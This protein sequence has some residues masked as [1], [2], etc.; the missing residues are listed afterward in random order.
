MFVRR[1]PLAVTEDTV[2]TPMLLKIQKGNIFS[3]FEAYNIWNVILR[4]Q[5]AGTFE[6]IFKLLFVVLKCIWLF[7]NVFGCFPNEV[8]GPVCSL[9]K[10]GQIDGRC[11]ASNFPIWMLLF[12][13]HFSSPNNICCIHTICEVRCFCFST[14]FLLQILFG[15]AYCTKPALCTKPFLF[16]EGVQKQN[17]FFSSLLLLN[18]R[19]QGLCNML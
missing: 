7:W 11:L 12:F 9:V 13:N 19:R 4:L 14:I 8:S 10:S 1:K 15:S 16:R 3:N 18:V 2:G 5:S 6:C 17:V